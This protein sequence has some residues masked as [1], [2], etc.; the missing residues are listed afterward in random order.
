MQNKNR[1]TNGTKKTHRQRRREDA[2]IEEF[3]AGEDGGFDEEDEDCV[4][5]DTLE[6]LSLDDE[7][8]EN[9]HREQKHTA[10]GRKSSGSRKPARAAYRADEY[11]DEYEEEEVYEYDEYEEEEAYEDDEYEEEEAYEDDEYEEEEMYEYE[12][13]EA[14][15]D[16]E[17][18]EEE[19]YEDDEYEEEEAYE[20]DEYEEDEYDE[21]EEDEYEYDAY[22]E[23]GILERF[24]YFLTH[25]SALDM[26]VAMLGIVVLAGVFLAGGLY[27]RAK[28][29]EKQVD[30]FASVGAEMEG[31]SVIGESGLIAVSESAKLAGMIDL[32]EE[33]EQ[34]E[35]EEEPAEDA[36]GAVEV[37]L[38]LTTIKSDLKIKFVNKATGKLI[39]GVPF[40]VEVVSSKKTFELK[41]EDKDGVIY[42]T[43]VDAGD[44]SVKIKPLADDRAADYKLPSSASSVKVTDTMTYKKVD[45][46]DEVKII[47]VK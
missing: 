42:Q 30:A 38:N 20:D 6:F 23:D 34:E 13:D 39:G 8:I 18:E 17:Y 32:E 5:D 3:F 41:D 46:A 35:T 45:V 27:I 1:R 21:Y 31:I 11:D 24:Q 37:V 10:A 22:E 28:S 14:Y 29:L 12:E 43:G 2:F 16:D 44:Y 19:M 33:E 15:E 9:Y 36:K 25:M 47:E 7:M 40:E 26:M 4:T